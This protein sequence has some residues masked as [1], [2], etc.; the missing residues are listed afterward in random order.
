MDKFII[1]TLVDVT[2]THA[3]RGEDVTKVHQQANFMTLYQ[4]IGLRT[5]P[6]DFVV[7]KLDNDSKEF[8]SNYKDAK[9][10]W[11]V[12]FAVEHVDSLH[13]DMMLTDFDLVPFITGLEECAEFKESVFYT[14][15]KRKCNIIF[16]KVDK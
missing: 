7:K 16:S 8:G 10:Y 11:Q 4:V 1:K 13:V 6:V 15:D 2:Q 9:C 12:E 3:R 14:Q 5:N